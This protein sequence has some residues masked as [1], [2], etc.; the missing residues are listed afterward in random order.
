MVIIRTKADDVS[1]Q[2]VSPLSIL[3]CGAGGEASAGGDGRAFGAGA[4]AA[5][6]PASSARAGIEGARVRAKK[7][8]KKRAQIF[9]C[10]ATLNP[11]FYKT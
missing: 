3:G 9:L 11:P 2:A 1:I 5:G 7:E 10:L 4:I 8:N 6:E